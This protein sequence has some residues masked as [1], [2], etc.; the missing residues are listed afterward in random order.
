MLKIENLNFSYPD[1]TQ[2]LKDVDVDIPPEHTFAIL[3]QSGSGKTTLLNC[4]ARFLTPQKGAI[5]L[6]GQNIQTLSGAEFRSK[7]GVVFQQLNLFPHMSIL[8]NL[9]LAPRTVQLRDRRDCKAS[10]MGMLERLGIAD[11]ANSYPAQISGG[12]AQRAAI[13]RGLMLQPEYM[14]LDEPTSALDAKTSDEFADWL[15]ELRDDTSFI[16]VTHDLRFARRAAKHGIAMRQGRVT[17]SGTLDELI[18]D[19][20]Q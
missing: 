12:Q 5:W 14:L 6:N 15:R 4:L 1:G 8:D 2:A 7:V 11:L 17:C 3:G 16:V 13:A 19:I 20:E 9:T 10:A 18:C